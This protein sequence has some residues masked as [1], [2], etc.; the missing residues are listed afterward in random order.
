MAESEIT[1]Y[2]SLMVWVDDM[3]EET[4]AAIREPIRLALE[5]CR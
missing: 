4:Q 1:D 2:L 5:A 3:G